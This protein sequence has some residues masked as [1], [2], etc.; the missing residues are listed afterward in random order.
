M[1]VSLQFAKPAS[2]FSASPI[3]AQA[4]TFAI[5]GPDFS[6]FMSSVTARREDPAP[7]RDDTRTREPEAERADHR[8]DPDHRVEDRDKTARHSKED[9]DRDPDPDREAASDDKHARDASEKPADDAPDSN[10]KPDSDTTDHNDTH[11]SATGSDADAATGEQATQQQTQAGSG[12][13][14]PQITVAVQTDE[15]PLSAVPADLITAQSAGTPETDTKPVLKPDQADQVM[16]GAT[17]QDHLADTGAAAGE[18]GG[19][20]PVIAQSGTARTAAGIGPKRGIKA[21]LTDIT[22]VKPTAVNTAVQNPNAVP[23]APRVPLV[24]ATAG[25]VT[26]S[27]VINNGAISDGAAT[28]GTTN[29][30]TGNNGSG[31]QNNANGG[32]PA[33]G[34]FPQF[35]TAVQANPQKTPPD[36]RSKPEAGGTAPTAATRSPEGGS[37]QTLTAQPQGQATAQG[38][39]GQAGSAQQ[40]RHQSQM[41]QPVHDQVAVHIKNAVKD[42]MDSIRI[43]MKPASL[44]RVEVQME[45]TSEGRLMAVIQA[46][47]KESYDL[48]R[49]DSRALERALQDAGFDT[50]SSSFTFKHKEEGQTGGGGNGQPS[51]GLPAGADMPEDGVILSAAELAGNV[52]LAYGVN[53]LGNVDIRI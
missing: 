51:S 24:Q 38:A 31:Q 41:Q 23:T 20:T 46:D 5:T 22:A 30:G 48:L 18:Q 28:N 53:A 16:S 34:T 50:D 27:G 37:P 21:D 6:Q 15:N 13:S 14:G 45:I 39:A 49:Q 43:Q 44:G 12:P 8:E 2:H 47:S 1:D 10:A 4:K 11:P 35:M 3:G 29:S 9:R 19:P 26:G 25:E 17:G 42:G 36:F 40:A 33:N 52:N 7:A 32:Q